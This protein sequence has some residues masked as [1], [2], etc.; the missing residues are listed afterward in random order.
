MKKKIL[1]FDIDGTMMDVPSGMVEPLPSTIETIEQLRLNGHYS[2]VATARAKM[3]DAFSNINFDGFIFC[4]GNYIE[5]QDNLIYDNFFLENQITFLIDLFNQYEGQYIF[6]G[7]LGRW[8]SLASH[9]LILRH[10]ELFGSSVSSEDGRQV[11]W[12]IEDV[13]ANI[14]TAL[15]KTEEQLFDCKSKLPRDW[16]VDAYTTANIRMD[17]HLPGYTKGKAVQYLSKKLGIA[18]E[19]AYAFGD[20]CNDIE[21]LQMVKYGIAMGNGTDEIKAIA[22]DVTDDVAHDGI[23]N[24]LKKYKAI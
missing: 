5:F 12:N 23:Y 21:M 11:P 19:D 3:P 15:F 14:V 13:H 2:V 22:Y 1:F 7:H 10:A 16:V 8:T 20:A 24:A 17:I 4:N 9:P 6:S 18:F